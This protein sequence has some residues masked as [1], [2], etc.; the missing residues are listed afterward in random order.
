M[1]PVAGTKAPLPWWGI[2]AAALMVVGGLGPWAKAL[3]VV[4]VSGREGDGWILVAGGVV[5]GTLFAIYASRPSVGL[6][7]AAGTVG[8]LCAIVAVVD[9]GS[10]NDEK[11]LLEPA[12]GI[13][14]SLVASILCALTATV[15]P[16]L[17]KPR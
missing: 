8:V 9:I 13:Y 4:D 5:A 2:A 16:A 6:V 7:I 1:A 10:I 15:T 12:W 14:L 11:P 17:A 3:G